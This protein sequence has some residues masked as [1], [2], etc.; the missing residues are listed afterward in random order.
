MTTDRRGADGAGIYR[1]EVPAPQF[2]PTPDNVPRVLVDDAPANVLSRH[3]DQVDR[4]AKAFLERFAADGLPQLKARER[5]VYANAGYPAAAWQ[6]RISRKIDLLREQSKT[7]RPHQARNLLATSEGARR[8]LD[9]INDIGIVRSALARTVA[10]GTKDDIEFVALR[11]LQLGSRYQQ[12]LIAP[13]EPHAYAG[14]KSKA[15]PEP[16]RIEKS[17]RKLTAIQR[18]CAKVDA[19]SPK[20]NDLARRRLVAKELGVDLRKLSRSYPPLPAK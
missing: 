11:A 7:A 9:V 8:A 14:R 12:M 15:G 3:L 5:R 18:A 13:L 19:E 6:H 20:A 1:L 16:Q 17:D 4:H 2:D 10:G